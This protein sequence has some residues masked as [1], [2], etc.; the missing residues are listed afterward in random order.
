[1]MAVDWKIALPLHPEYRTLPMVWYV[2]PL[3]PITAAA[4]AGQLA[5]KG[6]I[7]DVNELR[8]PVQYLANLL[9]AG[10]PAPV[11]SALE[12]MLAMRAWQ[13]SRHVDGAPDATVLAQV[14]LDEAEA[15]SMYRLLAIANY[16]DRFVI[17]ST[18]R[19]YAENAFELRGGCGF[20]FG[21]GCSDGSSEASLFGSGRR[22][23]IPVKLVE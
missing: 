5:T 11:I 4:A 19:E 16:E 1:R 22:R 2:P 3:S 13:R 14:G 12:R 8:I 20:S 6:V 21:N 17:P 15:E 18:H 10:D 23:T 7:P 9:T